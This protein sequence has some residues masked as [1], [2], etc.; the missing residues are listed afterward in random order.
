ME[1]TAE[2]WFELLNWSEFTTIE[3]MLDE[4]VQEFTKR[5]I[6]HNTLAKIQQFKQGEEETLRYAILR[7]KQYVVRCPIQELP[8]PERQISCFIKGLRNENL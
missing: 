4:F 3:Q 7:F 5:G 1:D 6:E 2:T 8:T